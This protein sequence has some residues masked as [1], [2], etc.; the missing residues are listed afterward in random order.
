MVPEVTRIVVWE[1]TG[2]GRID[3]PRPCVGI[4]QDAK[5]EYVPAGEHDAALAKL[6]REAATLR[7]LASSLAFVTPREGGWEST[8][9][10]LQARARALLAPGAIG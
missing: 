7:E 1:C 10:A 9:R 6:E 8:Y 2:C 5:A 3:H 4:C